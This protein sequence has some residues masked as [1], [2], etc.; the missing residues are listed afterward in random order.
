MYQPLFLSA[1]EGVVSNFISMWL[2]GIKK[3][4]CQ[5]AKMKDHGLSPVV[6]RIC[7]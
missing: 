4:E 7:F 5:V 3:E 6:F 1:I 2:N